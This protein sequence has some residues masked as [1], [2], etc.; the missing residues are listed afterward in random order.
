M[1]KSITPVK[2]KSQS[3]KFAP[4]IEGK[5]KHNKA[6]A[7]IKSG[8]A[9]S[10]EEMKKF[11]KSYSKVSA[12][13]AGEIESLNFKRNEVVNEVMKEMNLKS[14]SKQEINDLRSQAGEAFKNLVQAQMKNGKTVE[15][16]FHSDSR[17]IKKYVKNHIGLV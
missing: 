1:R 10:K 15:E 11:M 12:V 4:L 7:L 8:K 6:T 14:V 16:I 2:K 9:L 13:K 3:A 5:A 17:V